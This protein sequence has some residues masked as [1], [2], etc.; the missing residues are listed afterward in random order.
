MNHRP[1]CERQNKK[2]LKLKTIKINP[3][4]FGWFLIELKAESVEKTESAES[5]DWK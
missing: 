4:M 1:E 5:K 3:Q 2:I